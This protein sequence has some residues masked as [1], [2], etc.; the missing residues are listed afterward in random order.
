MENTFDQLEGEIPWPG[1]QL[2]RRLQ[3]RGRTSVSESKRGS[4]WMCWRGRSGRERRGGR[5]EGERE[6][7]V[8][9]RTVGGKGQDRNPCSQG[10]QR[11]LRR[12]RMSLMGSEHCGIM[13]VYDSFLGPPPASSGL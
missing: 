7:G 10:G 13:C 2:W 6:R 3:E 4:F 9:R 1:F 8:R 11:D 5:R 12:I